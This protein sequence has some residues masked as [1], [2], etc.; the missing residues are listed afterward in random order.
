MHWKL[1]NH[2]CNK[3]AVEIRIKA[4]DLLRKL[5]METGESAKTRYNTVGKVIE[6]SWKNISMGHSDFP[7][8]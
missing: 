1:H 8:R 3:V 5:D 2:N 4:Y 6:G 7:E